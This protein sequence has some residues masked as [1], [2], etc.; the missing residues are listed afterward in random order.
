VRLFAARVTERDAFVVP[1][2][3]LYW[4]VMLHYSAL[5]I[6]HWVPASHLRRRRNTR[7]TRG[8][9]RLEWRKP[10]P[11]RPHT[12]PFLACDALPSTDNS[13]KL[14][15][16]LLVRLRRQPARYSYYIVR[17]YVQAALGRRPPICLSFPPPASTR[18]S[19]GAHPRANSFPDNLGASAC[20]HA[21]N[22]TSLD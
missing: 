2:E 12:W 10:F 13:I 17:R 5:D 20:G 15:A 1:S 4:A 6:I 14:A 18:S 9:E 21:N 8:K 22:V 3:G 7:T 19:S 11:H 16:P